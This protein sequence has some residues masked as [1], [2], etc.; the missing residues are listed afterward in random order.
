[1]TSM[2][3][4]YHNATKRWLIVIAVIMVMASCKVEHLAPAAESTKDISGSWSVI[5]ATRNG[6]DLTTVVDF[7]QFKITFNEGKYTLTNKLPFIVNQDGTYS[8]DDP[9]YP[10]QITFKSSSGT[11]ASTAFNFPI[12]NGVRNLTLTFS[13]GCPD[14]TYVYTLKKTN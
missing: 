8:L 9:N 12:V 3:S 1:M 6:T 7:T 4:F 5:A 2:K 11:T 14:N 13:P 10:F